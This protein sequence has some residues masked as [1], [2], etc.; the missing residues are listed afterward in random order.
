MREP[1]GN[2]GVPQSD[3]SGLRVTSV[4][5]ERFIIVTSHGVRVSGWY[6]SRAQAEQNLGWF[7]AKQGE[8]S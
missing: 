3:D 1:W 5:V 7:Q 6:R 8:Q 2:D 4:M